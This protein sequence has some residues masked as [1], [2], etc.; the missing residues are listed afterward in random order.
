MSKK[1]N[2]KRLEVL[3]EDISIPKSD[4]R[5]K[6][7]TAQPCVSL[8]IPLDEARPASPDPQPEKP[9]ESIELLNLEN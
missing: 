6:E 2:N 9:H 7:E 8:D 3:F 5:G 4:P 1:L